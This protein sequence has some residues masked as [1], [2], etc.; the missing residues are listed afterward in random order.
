MLR[1]EETPAYAFGKITI[2]EQQVFDESDSTFLQRI[3]EYSKP[4]SDV[5]QTV[6]KLANDVHVLT[7]EEVI[8]RE[9]LFKEGDPYDQRL[10]DESA[11]HLRRLGFIG[12]INILSDTLPNNTIDVVVK[13]RDRWSLSPSM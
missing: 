4:A 10:V 9:L 12:G 2:E 3:E 6:R 13:T 11:R 7:R 5:A 1:G 8:R